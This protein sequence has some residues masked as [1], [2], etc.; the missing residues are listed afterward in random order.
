MFDNTTNSISINNINLDKPGT[1]YF[2]LTF[3][4]KITYNKITGHTDI[5][6]RSPITP[7]TNQI[8]NCQDGYGDNPL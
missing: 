1:I 6:I 7:T 5:D 3:S 4:R 8:L 2:I